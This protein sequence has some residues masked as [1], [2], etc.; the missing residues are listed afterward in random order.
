MTLLSPCTVTNP[1]C[2][3]PDIFYVY[4]WERERGRERP[5]S[6]L[7][8]CYLQPLASHG[9]QSLMDTQKPWEVVL[10]CTPLPPLSELHPQ[11]P[12]LPLRRPGDQQTSLQVPAPSPCPC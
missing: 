3:L 11:P 7:I 6:A 9:T 2:L 10:L 5:Q 12:Y 1:G 8:R 4:V